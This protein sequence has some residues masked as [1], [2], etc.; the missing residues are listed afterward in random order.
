MATK[1]SS[2]SAALQAIDELLSSVGLEHGRRQLLGAGYVPQARRPLEQAPERQSRQDAQPGGMQTLRS[3]AMLDA[4]VRHGFSTRRGGVSTVYGDA[5]ELNLGFT[6]SDAPENVAE[7]RAR[8]LR[9][10]FGEERPLVTLR[11]VHSGLSYQ[12]RQQHAAERACMA[13]D[14][15]MTD[16][17]GI[18]LG[19]QTADCVPVLV[20]D[21]VRGAVAAFHAGWR[22]TLRRIVER[23]IGQMRLAFGSQPQDL[24]AAVGP[25]IGVC[26]YSVGEEV[27]H[28]FRSQFHYANELFREVSD[29]DPI[30]RKYPM[31]FLT[32]R[33]PGHSDLGPSIHL[34]LP[35]ANRRQLLD[36]GIPAS[37]IEISGDCTSCRRDLFFSYRAENA[38]CGRMLSVISAP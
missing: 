8:L 4:G 10:V 14:G 37:R 30:R 7:N 1:L 15:L 33:A 32:Q 28:A 22:G 26:C 5:G 31:L 27:E 24:I 11:Q 23:G 38:F 34:D 18:V 25:S 12:V 21:P 29:A 35:E 16:E 3:Q 13:G 19:I 36:A 6:A 2:E 17:P 20:A 9:D